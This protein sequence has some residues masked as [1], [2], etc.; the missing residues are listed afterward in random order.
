MALAIPTFQQ[1][2]DAFKA[3][4]QA[5]NPALTDFTEGSNLDAI[6][7]G[8]SVLADL[9]IR[10]A[11]AAFAAQFVDTATGTDLDALALDRFGIERK[12]AS[13]A[14]GYVVFT[15]GDGTGAIEVPAGTTLRATVAGV[16]V[17]FTTDSLIEIAD[18]DDTATVRATCTETGTAG[19]VAAAAVT[20]IVDTLD[21]DPTATVS[22]TERMV[23][24]AEEETDAAFRDRIRRYFTTL[25]K[26]TVAALEA[27]AIS[28]GGVAFAAV[29]ESH[30][31]SADGGYV[32]LLVADSEGY[33]NAALV[34]DVEAEIENWRA[35][36]IWVQ[37]DGA[38]RQEETLALTIGV[39]SGS[40]QG[41]IRDAVKPVMLNLTD[42]LAPGAT[43][44]LSAVVAAAHSASSAIRYVTV[45]DPVA[46]IAPDTELS[47]VRVTSSGLTLSFIE[48]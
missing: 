18:G 1:L 45:T 20:T 44:Y 3:E 40:D 2:Y 14:Y 11:L 34:E 17:S 12:A 36:G 4:V 9:V 19:N 10:Q 7:G 32:L 6:A 25:R 39:V 47:I 46:D 23:G 41:A 15:R 43:L 29:D 28:V 31:M 21:D 26:G 38:E 42:N 35:A 8:A 37:V 5:R 13:S 24:G 22:N 30:R 33:S 48:V 16:S 27:G